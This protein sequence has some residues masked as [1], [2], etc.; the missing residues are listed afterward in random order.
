MEIIPN[1]GVYVFQN[2]QF[3]YDSHIL[4]PVSYEDLDIVV[5]TMENHPDWTII[6]NGH[7]DSN[8]SM[9]YNL[10]LSAKRAES[11]KDYLVSKGINPERIQ[12]NGLGKSKPLTSENDKE[13]QKKNRRV[14]FIFIENKMSKSQN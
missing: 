8:G 10:D 12:C 9:E 4:L 13:S 14:E 7:T 11:V 6:I 1:P 2:V 5:L 3:N